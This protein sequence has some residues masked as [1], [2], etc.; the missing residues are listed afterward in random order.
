MSWKKKFFFVCF[1]KQGSPLT[2][3]EIKCFCFSKWKIL[4]KLCEHRKMHFFKAHLSVILTKKKTV[5]WKA[6]R[7]D[8][9]CFALFSFFLEKIK[10]QKC[11]NVVLLGT[12]MKKKN[13]K[14]FFTYC[15]T[16]D[17][18]PKQTSHAHGHVAFSGTFW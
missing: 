17:E 8:S 1:F 11:V 15:R 5:W 2:S 3:S 6:R 10:F 13:K 16:P 7:M 18:K 14:L 9:C 4:R 12:F